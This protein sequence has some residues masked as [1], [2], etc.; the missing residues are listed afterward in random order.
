MFAIGLV[1]TNHPEAA[2]KLEA[3]P[4]GALFLDHFD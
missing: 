1:F 3:T 4:N 2:R